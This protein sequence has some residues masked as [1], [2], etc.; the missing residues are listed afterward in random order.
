MN[1]SV[2]YKYTKELVAVGLVLRE[3]WF[4]ATVYKIN[5]TVLVSCLEGLAA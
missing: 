3:K 1:R 5:P 2:V 4:T